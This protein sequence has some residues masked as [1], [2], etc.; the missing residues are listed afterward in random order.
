MH[1]DMIPLFNEEHPLLLGNGTFSCTPCGAESGVQENL[2]DLIWGDAVDCMTNVSARSAPT[3]ISCTLLTCMCVDLLCR[4]EYRVGGVVFQFIFFRIYL[5]SCYLMLL[6]LD[7]EAFCP[8]TSIE[9]HTLLFI[10]Q[11]QVSEQNLAKKPPQEPFHDFFL[12]WQQQFTHYFHHLL[13]AGKSVVAHRMHDLFDDRFHQVLHLSRQYKSMKL[14]G[15]FGDEFR[16]SGVKP[17]ESGS[18]DS[19]VFY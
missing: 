15:S 11:F 12:E 13:A 6:V 7:S 4:N 3:L 14:E 9:C 17:E 8:C 10:V 18:N 5:I 1:A 19:F 2:V 16:D